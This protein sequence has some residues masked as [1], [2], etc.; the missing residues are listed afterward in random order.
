[1][2][3]GQG[4]GCPWDSSRL[5]GGHWVPS[6]PG[7]H[8]LGL[9]LGASVPGK[10]QPL[11]HLPLPWSPGWTAASGRCP[12]CVLLSGRHA[13]RGPRLPHLGN[14]EAAVRALSRPML[15]ALSPLA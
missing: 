3:S 2:V 12:R 11:G 8:A 10:T 4:F 1:M 13:S 5:P 9:L 15:P 6:V 7:A 14:R